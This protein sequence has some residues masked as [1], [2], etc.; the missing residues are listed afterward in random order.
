MVVTWV[1]VQS[2]STSVVEY[3]VKSLSK[4]AKGH[5]DIFVDGGPEKRMIYIHRVTITGLQPGQQYGE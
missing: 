2:T 1:T 5:E 4:T 3:G